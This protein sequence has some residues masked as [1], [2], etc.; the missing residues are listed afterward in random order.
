MNLTVH[1]ATLI[2]ILKITPWLAMGRWIERLNHDRSR[3]RLEEIL[4]S[5]VVPDRL[6]ACK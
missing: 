2:V 1:G 6:G 4:Q 5:R 3:D